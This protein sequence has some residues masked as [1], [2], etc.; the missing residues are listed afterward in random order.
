MHFSGWEK[1]G[2]GLLI[3]AWVAFGANMIGNALV[4]VEKPEKSAY[5]V[6]A[7]DDTEKTEAKAESATADDAL[8]LLASADV[9]KGEKVFKKCKACHSTEE[10]GKNKVGPNLWNVVGRAKAAAGGF[11]YSPAMTAKGGDWGYRDLD[12]FLANP[13][14][15]VSGTKM[16]FAGV[17]KASDRA[18]VILYLRSLSSSPIALP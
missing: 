15:Y 12:D 11:K 18:A 10:G 14:G 17:K 4:H 9:G 6:V 1:I 8:T 13:K 16:S 5:Q 3:A 7:A 2:F